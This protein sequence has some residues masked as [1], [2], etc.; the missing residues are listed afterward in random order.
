MIKKF[1]FP[2]T[3]NYWQNDGYGID[4]D[5]PNEEDGKTANRFRGE[6]ENFFDRYNDGGDMTPYIDDRCQKVAHI[7]WRFES[8]NDCLY[9]R[10]DA[11]LSEPLTDDETEAL[12]DWICGQNSDGLGEGFEQQE[13]KVSNGYIS[14]SFWDRSDDYRIY[15]EAEFDKCVRNRAGEA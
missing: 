1:Y 2:L 7:E 3:V 12:K 8:V 13:I 10:V 14:V 6:I 11:V 15:D 9:G 4:C 5:C